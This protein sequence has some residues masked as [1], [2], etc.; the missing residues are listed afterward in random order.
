MWT[1][2]FKAVM[3]LVQLA[4]VEMHWRGGETDEFRVV[5]KWR[6]T[7]VLDRTFDVIRS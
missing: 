2:I 5:I 1:K 4:D 7:V 6:G 3:R